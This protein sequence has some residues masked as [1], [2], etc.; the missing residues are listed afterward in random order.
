MVY[1]YTLYFITMQ[2]TNLQSYLPGYWLGVA[3]ILVSDSIDRVID[4]DEANYRFRNGDSTEVNTTHRLKYDIYI[5]KYTTVGQYNLLYYNPNPPSSLS[6]L[7]L[8]PH[9][10]VQK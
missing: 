5:K 1:T 3:G 6:R 7:S 9:N 10:W 2:Q 4:M 8:D